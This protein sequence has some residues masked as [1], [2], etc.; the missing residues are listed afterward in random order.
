MKEKY[1][2]LIKVPMCVDIKDWEESQV[3]V[4]NA[5]F[6]TIG[7]EEV[8][9]TQTNCYEGWNY[10]GI[11]DQETTRFWDHLYEFGENTIVY[12]LEELQAIIDEVNK[13]EV[14]EVPPPSTNG[15]IPWSGG[16][17]PI[18]EGTV[19]DVKHRDGDIHRSKPAGGNFN[20]R[21]D[22]I[23]SFGDITAYRIVDTAVAS[24]DDDTA[25]L[26]EDEYV[27]IALGETGSTDFIG[28]SVKV[29]ANISFDVVIKG[30]TFTLTTEELQELYVQL[31][32][33]ENYFREWSL[34]V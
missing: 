2:S 8:E 3:D 23:G 9:T 6:T 17:M 31:C 7:A 30:Q 29:T 1:T 18:P 27:G 20:V 11:D 28:S 19:I 13:G 24:S 25:T 15:W 5:I 14:V 21:W 10:Y 33:V 34:D 26:D 16:E 4:L 22:H 12:T 32:G